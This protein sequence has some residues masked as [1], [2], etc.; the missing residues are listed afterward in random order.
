M[1]FMC[2]TGASLAAAATTTVPYGRSK[3]ILHL[4]VFMILYYV[5]LSFSKKGQ[6]CSLTRIDACPKQ[7][8]RKVA[9]NQIKMPF[10]RVLSSDRKGGA[11]PRSQ[12]Q[13]GA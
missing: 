10:Y 5:Q 1:R 4:F 13:L 9:K 2:T 11:W 7:K 3:Y 8:R 12:A 6:Y